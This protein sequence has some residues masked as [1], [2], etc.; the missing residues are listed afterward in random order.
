M[1]SVAEWSQQLGVSRPRAYQILKS[2]GVPIKNRKIDGAAATAIWARH[3]DELQAKR[4][5]RPA[6]VRS[7]ANASSSA[8]SEPASEQKPIPTDDSV[9]EAQRLLAWYKVEGAEI[10]MRKQQGELV[11]LRPINLYLAGCITRA[12]DVFLRIGPELRDRL[13]GTSDPIT[14]DEMIT[15]EVHRGLREMS[16]YRPD[17]A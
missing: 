7:A 5:G 8:L 15:A 6:G 16:E 10:E 12:R 9:A 14:C 3:R 13:A 11:E 1:V 2:C 4:R 17:A